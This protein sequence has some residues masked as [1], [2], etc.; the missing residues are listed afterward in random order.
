M[1]LGAELD[2]ALSDLG[3][4]SIHTDRN[5]DFVAQALQDG[6]QPLQLFG[7]GDA[8]RAGPGG[9]GADI[10][11]VRSASSRATALAKARSGSRY[12]PPSEKEIR[13]YVEHAQNQ[14]VL[15]QADFAGFQFPVV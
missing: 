5:S 1:I 11:N 14:G 3:F 12:L 8:R 4:V 9:L 6:N 13:R 15:A 10:E 2:R 7:G